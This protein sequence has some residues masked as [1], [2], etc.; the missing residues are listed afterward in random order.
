MIKNNTYSTHPR[1]YS[2]YFKSK[3]KLNRLYSWNGIELRFI[4]P[5][6]KGFNFLIVETGTCLLST[7]MYA[8]G[9]GGINIPENIRTFEFC[10]VPLCLSTIRRKNEPRI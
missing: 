10:R 4:R 9:F 3:F 6:R 1:V 7:H 5:T 2:P 8:K